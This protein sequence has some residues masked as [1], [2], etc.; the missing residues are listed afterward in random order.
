MIETQT[1]SLKTSK[2][3]INNTANSKGDTDGQT[4]GK[5]DYIVVFENFLA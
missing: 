5:T 3:A 1:K 2:E 4:W